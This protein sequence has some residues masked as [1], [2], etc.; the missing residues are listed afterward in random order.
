LDKLIAGIREMQKPGMDG[1]K[2]VDVV[3]VSFITSKMTG[4]C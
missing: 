2:A 1:E 3:L 4:R